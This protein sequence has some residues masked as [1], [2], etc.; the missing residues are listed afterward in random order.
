MYKRRK[1]RAPIRRRLYKRSVPVYVP[2]VVSRSVRSVLHSQFNVA[3]IGATFPQ[4]GA[5]LFLNK[6]ALGTGDHERHSNRVMLTSITFNGWI[7]LLDTSRTI[8]METWMFLWIVYDRTPRE[9]IP[10]TSDVFAG[11]VNDP[12]TW[13]KNELS[14]KRFQIVGRWRHKFWGGFPQ[15]D[16]F[17]YVAHAS[18]PFKFCKIFKGLLVE[19]LDNSED[20]IAAIDK[21]ALYLY[22]ASFRDEMPVQI[23]GYYKLKFLSM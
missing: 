2:R 11:G 19:Y 8:P 3:S 22:G 23:H 12:E 5:G 16:F 13:R 15:R 17:D 6:L 10:S 9:A 20:T 1:T 14:S 7:G 21:G 4:A 18:Q